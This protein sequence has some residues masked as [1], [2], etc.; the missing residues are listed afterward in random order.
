MPRLMIIPVLALAFT[1][2]AFSQQTKAVDQ[3]TR[4]KVEA[5]VTQ[6]VDALNR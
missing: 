1:T 5:I 2:P 3:Q 4:Q 6:Y